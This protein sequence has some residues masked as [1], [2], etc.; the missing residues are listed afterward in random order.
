MPMTAEVPQQPPI[1]VGFRQ[2]I[3]TFGRSQPLI[4]CPVT[5]TLRSGDG[6]NRVLMVT[7]ES[8][9]LGTEEGATIFYCRLSEVDSVV[10]DEQ[11]DQILL[12][13]CPRISSP[14][15]DILFR[16]KSD[17][18]R[19]SGITAQAVF[20]A[21]Q[22]Y[23]QHTFRLPMPVLSYEDEDPTRTGGLARWLSLHEDALARISFETPDVAF[24]E[25]PR[26]EERLVDVR[27]KSPR[28]SKEL[29]VLHRLRRDLA[30]KPKGLRG[31]LADP[32]STKEPENRNPRLVRPSTPRSHGSPDQN[33]R[34]TNR[35]RKGS[36]ASLAS[37]MTYDSTASPLCID[38]TLS[39]GAEA[40]AQLRHS[41]VG[42]PVL[43][44]RAVSVSA[45]EKDKKDDASF[46]R[47]QANN[48]A[49]HGGRAKVQE[50][51]SAS[52]LSEDYL[53]GACDK[54]LAEPKGNAHLASQR[55]RRVDFDTG[56]SVGA[57]SAH[58]AAPPRS[59]SNKRSP[60]RS[61]QTSSPGGR[62]VI[63]ALLLEPPTSPS[64]VLS[65]SPNNDSF[66]AER[67]PTLKSRVL[68]SSPN[69]DSFTAE[70]EPT[71]KS[72]VLSSSPNNDSFAAEREPS[73]KS[74]VANEVESCIDSC[75]GG[76]LTSL[77]HSTIR[78]SE[79]RDVSRLSPPSPKGRATCSLH[80][81]MRPQFEALDAVFVRVVEQHSAKTAKT[82]PRVLAVCPGA[83]MLCDF[84]ANV[85]KLLR[86]KQLAAVTFDG[87]G[88]QQRLLTFHPKKDEDEAPVVIGL[89]DDHRNV[90]PEAD[91]LL[92][93]IASA[94][95]SSLT[96]VKVFSSPVDEETIHMTSPTTA[97]A[98]PSVGGDSAALER[99]VPVEVSESALEELSQLSGAAVA[100]L[101]EFVEFLESGGRA[102]VS[103]RTRQLMPA[104]GRFL[105]ASTVAGG[106]S[107]P[108][109]SS[110]EKLRGNGSVSPGAARSPGED[111]GS[112]RRENRA[113]RRRLESLEGHLASLG[114]KDPPT[115]KQ[116]SLASLDAF[117]AWRDAPDLM[118]SR[119]GSMCAGDDAAG[120]LAGGSYDL[121]VIA[122]LCDEE[123][124]PAAKP[125][126]PGRN[127]RSLVPSP[128]RAALAAEK[129]PVSPRSPVSPRTAAKPSPEAAFE[130]RGPAAAAF[131]PDLSPLLRTAQ[132][133]PGK[134]PLL[135]AASPRVPRL[136]AGS[137]RV[138][139]SP[140][141]G[142][143]EDPLASSFGLSSLATKHASSATT[144]YGSTGRTPES[145][146][147]LLR[148]K[149][150]ERDAE[151]AGEKLQRWQSGELSE[152]SM[153][154]CRMETEAKLSSTARRY[155]RDDALSKTC[156]SLPSAGPKKKDDAAKSEEPSPPSPQPVT[157]AAPSQ[158][159]PAAK[160]AEDAPAP[161]ADRTQGRRESDASAHSVPSTL[162]LPPA[163][164][165]AGGPDTLQS[166]LQRN[167][168]KARM[169]RLEAVRAG[170]AAEADN[171]TLEAMLQRVRSRTHRKPA[172]G[173]EVADESAPQSSGSPKGPAWNPASDLAGRGSTS[174]ESESPRRS[175][176]EYVC[177]VELSPNSDCSPPPE[178]P[179]PPPQPAGDGSGTPYTFDVVSGSEDESVVFSPAGSPP[180]PPPHHARIKPDDAGGAL[181]DD[182]DSFTQRLRTLVTRVEERQLKNL[183][184][185]T[186]RHLEFLTLAEL[187]SALSPETVPAVLR[188]FNLTAPT[189]SDQLLIANG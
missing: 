8:V 72:R 117:D 75:F 32:V 73:L 188:S 166:M 173:I 161:G 159:P 71:L 30:Q 141:R 124:L 151:S 170:L 129:P 46:T 54:H 90:H 99:T 36:S 25:I 88:K 67:E 70:R 109:A 95:L 138:R 7:K 61:D 143:D 112:L 83:V 3:E 165:G 19:S 48:K 85:K 126:N 20:A 34:V 157:T 87:E 93:A 31:N 38:R 39:F 106:V 50:R 9:A 69:N 128:G 110:R 186:S 189:S 28:E 147:E 27:Q 181:P 52:F 6:L 144:R 187:Q 123:V 130:P 24:W 89:V 156:G 43:F 51:G 171:L 121:R 136:R 146:K 11:T 17:D 66:A 4:V 42:T 174:P 140:R 94:S 40:E 169:Q 2:K 47:P 57:S 160:Q 74:R 180:A 179:Q 56:S 60:A 49:V 145:A 176:N 183:G 107:S 53:R 29:L 91:S 63:P 97:T 81:S 10:H 164:E 100:D 92:G 184:V 114:P 155:A 44:E 125:A 98:S 33:S 137:Q 104:L 116:A 122:E 55:N 5:Q 41:F 132:H 134:E 37:T 84:N 175:T 127:L 120:K 135:A 13:G 76:T 86:Y 64:P 162:A 108:A 82:V 22:Y 148:R 101:A 154:L 118:D 96:P 45:F 178:P 12:R 115:P 103:L 172:D 77:D 16:V 111:E 35:C 163:A 168:E 139:K 182:A 119:V 113:L 167:R 15:T 23:K 14:V 79:P 133:N 62:P 68:S 59:P 185:K 26:R 21:M 65:S 78:V 153:I 131:D 149:Q 142:S 158:Q 1:H 177:T 105:I 80:A 152:M 18:L 150:I 58:D 102:P